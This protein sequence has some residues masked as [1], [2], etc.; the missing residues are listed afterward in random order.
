MK[1]IPQKVANDKG[2]LTLVLDNYPLCSSAS[3]L[4]IFRGYSK[5]IVLFLK[6]Q[7]LTFHVTIVTVAS[8]SM[9]QLASL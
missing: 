4:S 5:V 3:L 8:N 2:Y 6:D 9:T 1:V 7:S